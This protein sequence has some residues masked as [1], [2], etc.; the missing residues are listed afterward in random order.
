MQNIERQAECAIAVAFPGIR[1]EEMRNWPY[2][3]LIDYMARAEWAYN[4][5]HMIPVRFDHLDEGR[6]GVEPGK[7]DPAALRK[8][9]IDPMLTI[10]PA[11]LRP[12]YLEYPLISGTRDWRNFSLASSKKTENQAQEGP[13]SAVPADQQPRWV[14]E[15]E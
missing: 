15:D 5:I 13:V 12:P 7:V 4:N 10:N 14:I 9:G 8:K 1:I 3:K 6:G 2:V 11:S